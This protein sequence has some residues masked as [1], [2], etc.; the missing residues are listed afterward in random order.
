VAVHSRWSMVRIRQSE[1]ALFA[2][3]IGL[4]GDV[5]RLN[6]CSVAELAALGILPVPWTARVSL[7]PPVFKP[8][9]GCIKP[10]G[11][12]SNKDRLLLA[13]ELLA[14][15]SSIAMRSTS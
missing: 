10:N 8:T 9:S 5:R 15:E 14:G 3:L 11:P 4:A 1:L 7:I 13:I 12:C 2:C 6:S